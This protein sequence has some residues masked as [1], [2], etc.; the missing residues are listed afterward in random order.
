VNGRAVLI[1]LADFHGASSATF[2]QNMQ[3]APKSRRRR[4][5]LLLLKVL[6]LVVLASILPV[7]VFRFFAP[8]VSTLMIERRVESWWA[9][10]KY[11]P[12]HQWVSLD[13]I[14]PSMAAA[15]I[16]AEDQ[17]FPSHHGFDWAAI[18]KAVEHNENSSRT[19]GASTLSQ[20][21]A[22]N[23]LLW[24]GRTWIRK[25]FEA[26]FTVLL[27]TFWNKRRILETYLNIAE[28]GDG[29]YGVEAAAQRYFRKPASRLSSE[30]AA[31]L[32]AVLPNPRRYKVN[33]PGPY[34]RERQQWILQQMSH[35]GG[36]H[37]ISTL[38]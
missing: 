38:D 20:Q 1:C 12:Q 2:V 17:N 19:R 34:V 37:L 16:A 7:V 14:A 26:Y 8:P 36:G 32:A 24:S 5:L 10:T 18:Q 11:S 25:G 15:V 28:F 21:T 13:K 33:P 6:G 30:E 35:L 4:I 27:E 23:L 29:I 3:V 9:G 31:L 22:K